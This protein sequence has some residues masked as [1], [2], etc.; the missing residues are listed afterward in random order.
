LD[1]NKTAYSF[2]K[3]VHNAKLQRG[4]LFVTY[5]A[6]SFVQTFIEKFNITLTGEK[7]FA[8]GS[9]DYGEHG[10]IWWEA[11]FEPAWDNNNEV[12]GVS[13][14]IRNVTDRKQ[15]EQ[16]IVSQNQ[17]LVNIAYIQ[18]HE[19]R[20]P[21]SSIMGLMNLIRDE[22]YKPPVEYLELLE[23]AINKLDSKMQEIV[24]VVNSHTV[25]HANQA[26]LF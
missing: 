1:Y 20:G 2:I 22:E 9:T 6:P 24:S 4:D 16:R 25:S 12:I 26:K 21:L 23:T 14:S 15:Y 7:C 18:S 11:G 10:E 3:K 17:S 19:Y 13:Y 5:I 8:E